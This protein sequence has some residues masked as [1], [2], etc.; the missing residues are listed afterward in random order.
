MQVLRFSVDSGNEARYST[1]FVEPFDMLRCLTKNVAGINIQLIQATV[2]VQ[3]VYESI[4]NVIQ[5]VLD[6]T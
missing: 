4:K 6:Y 5:A 1:R 2:E 3:S